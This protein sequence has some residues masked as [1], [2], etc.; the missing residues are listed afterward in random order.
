MSDPTKVVLLHQQVMATV[1][2]VDTA[3]KRVQLS[4]K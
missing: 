4:L 3:R 2:E 1:L